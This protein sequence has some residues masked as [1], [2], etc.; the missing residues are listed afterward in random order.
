MLPAGDGLLRARRREV[1]IWRL[2]D[3][4]WTA[5]PVSAGIVGGRTLT[6]TH[7]YG[8][9]DGWMYRVARDGSSAIRV[10]A[11]VG[12]L[13]HLVPHGDAGTLIVG[14]RHAEYWLGEERMWRLPAS[15][16]SAASWKG[17][18]WVS[19]GSTRMRLDGASIEVHNPVPGRFVWSEQITPAVVPCGD[20]WDWRGTTTTSNGVPGWPAVTYRL[21]TRVPNGSM[22]GPVDGWMSAPG[23]HGWN[24]AFMGSVWA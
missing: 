3:G 19:I 23:A 20:A 15:G 16:M 21:A 17:H 10:R 8:Y 24:M 6:D 1:E 4:Q 2:E 5:E 12:Y 7:L 13:E 14:T 9:D 18:P 11:K 22:P